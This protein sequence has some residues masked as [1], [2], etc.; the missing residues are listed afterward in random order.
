MP[1]MVGI[2]CATYL[3][4]D[5]TQ[6]EFD[7]QPASPSSNITPS[8]VPDETMSRLLDGLLEPTSSC[9]GTALIF[10]NW[11]PCH[12]NQ[13]MK[14][15]APFLLHAHSWIATNPGAQLDVA[16][17]ISTY[18]EQENLHVIGFDGDHFYTL[19]HQEYLQ[20]HGRIPSAMSKEAKHEVT[21]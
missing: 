16:K 5:G 2:N 21:S 4:S 8:G 12:C 20:H 7:F 1:T 9:K 3:N 14:F 18:K 13:V 6:V 17:I 10:V 15:N 11:K 19:H